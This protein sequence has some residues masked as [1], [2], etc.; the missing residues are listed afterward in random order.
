MT[1]FA[2]QNRQNHGAQ[3]QDYYKFFCARDLAITT[4]T[5]PIIPILDST[6]NHPGD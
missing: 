3:K 2:P 1:Q 5:A 4:F 6:L